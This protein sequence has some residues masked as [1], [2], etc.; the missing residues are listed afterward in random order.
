MKIVVIK[1]G[2]VGDNFLAVGV[3]STDEINYLSDVVKACNTAKISDVSM[4]VNE[5]N[6]AG[7]DMCY[8]CVST[9]HY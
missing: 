7:F 3:N 1:Y 2:Y 9:L 6:N 4:I 5:L 8:E